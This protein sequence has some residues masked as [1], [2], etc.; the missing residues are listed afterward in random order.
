MEKP[1]TGVRVK[2]KVSSGAK[3]PQKKE[4][5]GVISGEIVLDRENRERKPRN[6]KKG[7]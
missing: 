2:R 7:G 4:Y 5:W 1:E 3:L 6:G